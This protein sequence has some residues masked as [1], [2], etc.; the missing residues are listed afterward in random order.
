MDARQVM[1]GS[2]AGFPVH[3]RP[4]GQAPGRVQAPLDGRGVPASAARA[5]MPATNRPWVTPYPPRPGATTGPR[6]AVPP[7]RGFGL[8]SLRRNVCP[9]FYMTGTRGAIPIQ[10]PHLLKALSARSNL[11]RCQLRG[12]VHLEQGYVNDVCLSPRFNQCV[13]Y[14]DELSR[15]ERLAAVRTTAA[16]TRGSTQDPADLC[17]G[18]RRPPGAWPLRHPP[19]AG[20]DAGP[21][22]RARATRSAV[23]GALIA[24]TNGKGSVLA[25]AG[26]VPGAAG[27]PGRRDA[28][29]APRHLP[30]AAPIGGRPIAPAA[31]ARLVGEVLPVA[32]R[33]AR[34]HGP[35]TEFELLTAL[36]FRWFAEAGIELAVVE[37]GLGG[38][39][40]ATH[41]WDGG[42]AAIT[43]VDLD[44]TDR[45]G[46]TIAR[47]RP[48]E[49][50]DHRARRP[51]GDRAR[52]A[53]R[54]RSSAGGRAASAFRCVVA[55]APVLRLDR[56]TAIVVDLPGLGAARVGLL[57]RHQAA[58]VAVAD[59]VLDALA[60]GR[61]RRRAAGGPAPRVRRRP[62]AGPAGAPRRAGPGPAGRRGGAPR[63]RPQPGR[64]RAP[65]RRRSTTCGRPRG[66]G[67]GARAAATLVGRHG[68]QGRRRRRGRAGR[69][70]VAAG[71]ASWRP[72]LDGRGRSP[73]RPSP[74]AGARVPGGRVRSRAVPDGPRSSRSC[75][76]RGPVV[77]A[78]SLYLVGAARAPLVDDPALR[79]PDA[80]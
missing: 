46:P 56:A 51:R 72:R 67:D 31:F 76:R 15:S 20:P 6:A 53:R 14:E 44:H 18:A 38:R 78:G 32:D 8:P 63:R 39:L 11:S 29:A 10:A 24:G 48:R 50:R 28:Q 36:A 4:P 52:P 59:A 12:G 22:A 35:P 49:G 21:A 58:N 5:P 62:L 23:R 55:P 27:L 30:G 57:G 47:D 40:D 9:H 3:G 1:A 77:V 26:A 65:S 45:L 71:A 70:R 75:R 19:G 16:R 25:L 74:P 34:R 54:S 42:V 2:R 69:L 41:A 13:F 68:R 73:P 33:V 61:D 66:G 80:P 7:G 64:R 43:N 79:D 37:V 17:G 60:R